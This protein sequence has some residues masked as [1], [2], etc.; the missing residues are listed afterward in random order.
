MKNP[1]DQN[2]TDGTFG[3]PCPHQGAYWERHV[4][5]LELAISISRL[6]QLGIDKEDIL[7][8]CYKHLNFIRLKKN[9]CPK[10]TTTPK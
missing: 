7:D 2:P 8:D 9:I 3:T 6:R 10:C 1:E 4:A 5:S